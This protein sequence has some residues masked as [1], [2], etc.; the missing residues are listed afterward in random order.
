[1]R[2]R[3]KP[4]RGNLQK[5]Q[6]RTLYEDLCAD[7]TLRRCIHNPTKTYVKNGFLHKQL[8][9]QNSLREL[10]GRARERSLGK[11]LDES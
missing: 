5:N 1:M 3:E 9:N 2:R 7:G 4:G 8:E 11:S 10:L 6:P